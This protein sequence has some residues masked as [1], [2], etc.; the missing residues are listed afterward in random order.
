MLSPACAFLDDESLL[1]Q[2]EESGIGLSVNS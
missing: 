2:L 1:C